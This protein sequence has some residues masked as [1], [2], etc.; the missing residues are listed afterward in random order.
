MHRNRSYE[1]KNKKLKA[2]LAAA[3]EAAAQVQARNEE[4]AARMV[5]NYTCTDIEQQEA[6]KV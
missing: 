5:S 3:Q 1:A 4:Q 2:E 6:P